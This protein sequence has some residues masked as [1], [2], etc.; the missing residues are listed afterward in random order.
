MPAGGS[1]TDL[2]DED[3]PGPIRDEHLAGRCGARL[4]ITAATAA[5][6][7]TIARRI[8]SVGRRATFPFVQLSAREFPSEPARLRATCC[9]L[10]DAA[11]GG[12]VLVTDVETMGPSVQGRLIELL[13]ELALERAP[14]AAI[15]FVSG[16]TVRLRDRVM[17]G[18]FSE[19]LFYRLNALHLIVE[20]TTAAPSDR[21]PG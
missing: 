9:R 5:A 3:E 4:L 15:R 10:L 7:E 13:D 14:E 19:R 8:H 20:G 1:A 2:N 12:S 11:A 18:G 6:V 21:R 16:T 17:A